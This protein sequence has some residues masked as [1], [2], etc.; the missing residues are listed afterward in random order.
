M[1]KCKM[2]VT[3]LVLA[4]CLGCLTGCNGSNAADLPSELPDARA[5]ETLPPEVVAALDEAGEMEPFFQDTGGVLVLQPGGGQTPATPLE[6]FI[7]GWGVVLSDGTLVLN[8]A[9][10]QMVYD[11]NGQPV[12][13]DYE[14]LNNMATVVQG[15]ELPEEWRGLTIMVIP[16]MDKNHSYYVGTALPRSLLDADA[17]HSYEDCGLWYWQ[18]DG[19]VRVFEGVDHGDTFSFELATV[20]AV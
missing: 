5:N 12:Q 13:V 1:S 11:E 19:Y 4:L 10:F 20:K 8:E 16:P 18:E 17:P 14:A 9:H 6:I 2:M 15:L 7:G 3:W